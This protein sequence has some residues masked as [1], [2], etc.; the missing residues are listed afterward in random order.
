MTLY[1]DQ[2]NLVKFYVESNARLQ[3]SGDSKTFPANRLKDTC[4]DPS[5]MID[6][7]RVLEGW[8]HGRKA[9]LVFA[10]VPP[11]YTR[12]LSTNQRMQLISIWVDLYA[13]VVMKLLRER[14]ERES[15]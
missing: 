2:Y 13:S 5:V 4:E 3:A 12:N 14:L 15:V 6:G 1:P 8:K 10:Q 9:E 11:Q 7:L